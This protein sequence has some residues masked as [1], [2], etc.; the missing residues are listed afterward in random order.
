MDT[1]KQFSVK[2]TK[3]V[4][5]AN[6]LVF[7]IEGGGTKG[8]YAIGVIK[9][10]LEDKNT[11]LKM[12]DV[13]IFGGT[14]VGSYIA[15]ALALGFNED[16]VDNLSE[17]IDTTRLIDTGYWQILSI[18]RLSTYGYLYGD[19]GRL[20]LIKMILD[21]KF[22]DIKRDL[23]EIDPEINL[24]LS[25]ELTFGHLQMLNKFKPN[26]YKHLLINAIDMSREVQI[27][28]TSLNSKSNNITLANAMLA[29]SSIP[30]VYKTVD[31][32]YNLESDS[33]SQILQPSQTQATINSLVDGGLDNPS[34][35][36]LF[37]ENNMTDYTIYNL[38]FNPQPSYLR[39]DSTFVL[40]HRIMDYLL[41]GV[42]EFH[43]EQ[44]SHRNTSFLEVSTCKNSETKT[45]E[46]CKLNTIDISCKAGTFDM[47]TKVQVKE[48]IQKIYLE[49]LQ[50][51]IDFNN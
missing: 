39:I 18:Y 41:G 30:L 11:Y 46:K 43:K 49:C 51:E 29:S 15:T 8:I 1:I 45:K 44:N 26:I 25:T 12:S 9:Y 22:I 16:D 19:A 42:S 10:L 13:S 21:R 23:H 38:K 34:D 28:F 2:F 20:E 24:N 37:E 32:F 17:N 33:Y 14:S 40:L 27:F 6:K 48:I 50:G 36:F 3:Q 31:M 47:Y 35:Y 7:L 4:K 5:S